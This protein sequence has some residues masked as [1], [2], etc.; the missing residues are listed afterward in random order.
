MVGL[1]VF[2]ETF[3]VADVFDGLK[4]LLNFRQET[5]IERFVR[6]LGPLTDVV[7][8]GATA[9]RGCEIRMGDGKLKRQLRDIH[10]VVLAKLGGLARRVLNLFRFFEPGRKG[11]VGEQSGA[12]GAGVHRSH[13]FLVQI[14]QGL[15]DEASVL[16]GVLVVAE[17]AIYADLVDDEFEYLLGVTAKADVANFTFVPNLLNGWNRFVYDLL[18]WDKFDIVA[19]D[20]VEVIRAEAMEADVDGFGDALGGK[21]EVAQIVAA[22]FGA[23]RVT[24]PRHIAEGDS[25]HDLAHSAAVEGRGVDQIHAEVECDVNTL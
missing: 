6:P 20:D 1:I 5:L 15:V 14:G 19:Q 18:H 13:I 2:R 21:I 23:E 22:E 10:T 16:Q 4:D 3:G 17:N 24:I 12:E 9:D 25:Q 8:I 11:S 7:G